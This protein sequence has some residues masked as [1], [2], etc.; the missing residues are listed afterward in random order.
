MEL[1]G[2]R[3]LKPF[4]DVAGLVEPARRVFDAL[5]PELGA[6]FGQMADE[7]LLDLESRPGKAPG[8]YCTKLSLARH[9]L[10]LHE[11]GRRA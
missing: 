1:E 9:A 6:Q 11:R 10:H 5:D 3:P 4:S 8:G 7:G 2:A